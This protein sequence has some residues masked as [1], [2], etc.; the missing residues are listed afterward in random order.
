MLLTAFLCLKHKNAFSA[1]DPLR[2]RTVLPRLL[3]EF[4]GVAWQHGRVWQ[5]EGREQKEGMGEMEGT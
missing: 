1:K 4:E 5:E 3:D 2:E